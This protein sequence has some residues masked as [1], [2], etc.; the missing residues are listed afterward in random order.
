MTEPDR[1]TEKPPSGDPRLEIPQVLR[2]PVRHTSLEPRK[3]SV[4]GG[5]IGEA[6]LALAIG[7]DFLVVIAAGAGLGWLADRQFGWAPFGLVAGLA[8]GVVGGLIRLIHRLSKQDTRSSGTG[9]DGG[10]K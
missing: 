7:I 8:V 4:L 9:P 3:P 5:S 10:K 1:P 6:G 2:E